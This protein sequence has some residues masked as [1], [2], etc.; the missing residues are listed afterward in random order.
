MVSWHVQVVLITASTANYGWLV[1][2]SLCWCACFSH[3]LDQRLNG[4][5]IAGGSTV[6]L[7][8]PA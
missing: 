4:E 2:W 8:V 7:M 6:K 5:L 1:R 3:A